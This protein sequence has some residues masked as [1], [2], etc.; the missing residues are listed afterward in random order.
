MS[1]DTVNKMPMFP[2]RA[3]DKRCINCWPLKP[4]SGNYDSLNLHVACK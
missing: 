2:N 1:T 3:E 4:S